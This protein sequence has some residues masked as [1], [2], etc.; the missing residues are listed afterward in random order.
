MALGVSF[1]LH[2]FIIS[3]EFSYSLEIYKLHYKGLTKSL[4]IV[5][6]NS[7]NMVIENRCL[8]WKQRYVEF[9]FPQN[10]R[11]CGFLP[12]PWCTFRLS[13]AAAGQAFPSAGEEYCA[14]K[15]T[16]RL[17]GALSLVIT[18]CCSINHSLPSQMKAQH[19]LFETV[20]FMHLSFCYSHFLDCLWGQRIN[21]AEK[22][23]TCFLWLCVSGNTSHTMTSRLMQKKAHS[24][25]S[26]ANFIESF[27]F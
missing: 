11:M 21:W 19:I 24:F 17:T 8:C 15:G 20:S 26:L 14:V 3:V 23:D 22:D 10:S 1:S 16:A 13:E 9:F 7:K 6:S 5:L 27:F 12:S 25:H 2:H 18:V 4:Q